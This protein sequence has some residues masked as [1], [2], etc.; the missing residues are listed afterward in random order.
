MKTKIH[1]LLLIL[2]LA[3]VGYAQNSTAFQ[4]D[5]NLVFQVNRSFVTTGLLKDYGLQL[6]DVAKFHVTIGADNTIT[7]VAKL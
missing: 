1:Q 6:A 2:L 5:M 4:D 7:D 3:K